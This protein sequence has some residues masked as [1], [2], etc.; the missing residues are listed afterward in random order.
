MSRELFD[1]QEKVILVTGAAQGL[2]AAIGK[3]CAD[4]KATVVLVDIEQEQVHAL[5]QAMSEHVA[6]SVVAHVCDVRDQGQVRELV[7]S[8]VD[9]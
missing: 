6:G 2:G 4:Q 7:Q 8:V 1:L 5:T 3:A 9:A